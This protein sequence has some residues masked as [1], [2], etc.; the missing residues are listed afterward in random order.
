MD[1]KF[2]R[3]TEIKKQLKLYEIE[4]HRIDEEIK[5]DPNYKLIYSTQHYL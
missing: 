2:D 4:Q 3:N 1:D 5:K